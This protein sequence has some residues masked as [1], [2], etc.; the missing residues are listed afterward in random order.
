[1]TTPTNRPIDLPLP[2]EPIQRVRRLARDLAWGA[3]HGLWQPRLMIYEER[4]WDKAWLF[5]PGENFEN[6]INLWNNQMPDVYLL[7]AFGYL[8]K[9]AESDWL[10]SDKA[11][12]LLEEDRPESIFVSYRRS[13][14][15]ALAMLIA[16]ELRVE[17]FR[18]FLDIRSIALGDEWHT[19]LEN[20]VRQSNIFI[21]VIGPTTLE[22]DYVKEEIAWALENETARR[23]IP[24]VHAGFS[25]ADLATSPFPALAK[26]NPIHIRE[27]NAADFYAALQQLKAFLGV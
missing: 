2:D 13:I 18:P 3:L 27:D 1:M 6:Y 25:P 5:H 23:I 17:G 11:F 26:K 21:P 9:T 24:L 8:A 14:S 19:V 22:S 7:E 10:L 12:K 4:A 15:S 20:R 16:A